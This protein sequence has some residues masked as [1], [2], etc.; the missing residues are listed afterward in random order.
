MAG[1][2]RWAAV[3]R[4]LVIGEGASV[5]ALVDELERDGHVVGAVAK[6]DRGALEHVTI[7]CWL[8]LSSPERFLLGAVDSSMRGFV[9]QA[10]GAV[11][12]VGWEK[13][14]LAQAARN[15][16]PVA[17]LSADPQDLGPWLVQAR[18]AI[19]AM[20]GI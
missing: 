20:L 10:G 3:A 11:G 16:I 2:I 5:S 1:R 9:Y 14:V 4:I 18:G 17:A 13:T 12:G 15:A 19:D 6:P 8:L 7:V